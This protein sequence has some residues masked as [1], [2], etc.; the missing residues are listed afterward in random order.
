MR[1]LV[2]LLLE[3]L[4]GILLLSIICFVGINK[5]SEHLKSYPTYTVRFNDVDGLSVGSPVRLM[6]IQVGH[7]VRLELLESE[8]YVTFR[9]TQK[10]TK[11]PDGSIPRN[12]AA[13]KDF[14]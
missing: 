14:I 6:G 2:F 8:I 1:K 10:N 4:I 5:F 13:F 9:I 3:I 7:V 11:I 12:Y